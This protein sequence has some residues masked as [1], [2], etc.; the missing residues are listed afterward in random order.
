VE[1]KLVL[2]IS[3]LCKY[4]IK[5]IFRCIAGV[6]ADAYNSRFGIIIKLIQIS[7]IIDFLDIFVKFVKN[8]DGKK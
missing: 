5:E 3:F 2:C 4:G 1:Y 8:K 7:L 6:D